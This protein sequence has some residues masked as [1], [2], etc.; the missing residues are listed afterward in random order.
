MTGFEGIISEVSKC[1]SN[2]TITM[3]ATLGN[4]QQNIKSLNDELH[5]LIQL[6]NDMKENIDVARIEGKSPTSEINRWLEEV[7]EIER[8]VHRILA[9]ANHI[10]IGDCCSMSKDQ[11]RSAAKKCN[12]VKHLIISCSF[13]TVTYDMK[14]PIRP[15]LRLQAGSAVGQKAEEK[16]KQLM[17]YLNDDGIRRVAIWG[18]GGAG[19]TTMAKNLN[20]KLESSSMEEPFDVIVW[21]TVSK[22]LNLRRV[23]SDIASKLNLELDADE[24]STE[25]RASRLLEQFSLRK[26]TLLIL[27]DVW[28]KIDLN[29][30]GIPQGDGQISC[31]IVLI[32]RSFD[33]CQEMMADVA[34]KLDVLTENDAWSLFAENAGDVVESKKINQLARKIARECNGLPLAIKTMGKSM[35]RKR[36][37]QPWKNT[38]YQLKSSALHLGSIKKEVYIPLKLSFDSLPKIA[39]RCFLYCSLY[40][41][42]YSIKTCELIHCWAADGLINE[43]QSREESFNSGMTL[44]ETLKDACMLEQGDGLGTVKTHGMLRDVAIWISLNEE[45]SGFCCQ[46]SR[47]LQLMPEKL[48]NS[49]RKA[50]FMNNSILRLP[51]QLRGCSRLSVLFLQGNPLRKIPDGFFHEL[52]KIRVLN[53]SRT[54]ITTL[55]PSVLELGELHTLLLRDCCYLEVL[56]ELGA[57]YKL[58]VLDLHG[59]RITEL[60][61][62]MGM[63]TNLRELNLSCTHYLENIEPGSISVLSSLE[64]L[65]MSSS[66]YRWDGNCNVGGATFDEIILLEKLSVLRIR[67][68]SIDCLPSHS[69]W[70]QRL[71]EFNIQ[72]IQRKCDSTYLPPPPSIAKEKRVFLRGVNLLESG[73]DGLYFN[74]SALDLITCGSFRGLSHIVSKK[75]LYGLPN[76]K[77]L[78]LTSCDSITS[79]LVGE[80]CQK[81]TLPNLEHL[82]LCHLQTL[83]TMLEGMVPRGCLGRLKTIQVVSCP[84]LRNLISFALLRLVQNLEEIKVRDC[85]KMR[86]II[87]ATD[88]SEMLPKL[89]IIEVR[90]MENLVTICP[91]PPTCP[92]LERIKVSNCPK[93]EE[94]SLSA[95]DT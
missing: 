88:S 41:E 21:V 15:I 86:Q 7:E 26:K 80:T 6:K 73:L 82:Y 14:P 56:P 85:K 47:G 54:Q 2:F 24:D 79:L 81:S 33:V 22:D 93:L 13:L 90:D 25:Q 10:T 64:V 63:P 78:T 58:R 40:P 45:E 69:T 23:Q 59:T 19:K 44:L 42:N 27:D 60:P 43:H 39:Q 89:K 55:P 5:K 36:T 65:D 95:C 72:I 30:V 9:A 16:V 87:A 49:I 52:R 20:K 76:L 75:S 31:K 46:S 77:S 37:I 68:D 1:T 3:S 57:L 18:V 84:E 17:D 70:L 71:K 29:A 91:I 50:S 74:A 32:T 66:A 62:E 51:G 34:L 4:F 35:R 38:L 67:L 12:E 28:E 83:R 8:E 11:L 53:L 94:L 92:L 48:Q 61:K